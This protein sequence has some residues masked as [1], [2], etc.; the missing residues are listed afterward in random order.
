MDSQK[1]QDLGCCLYRPKS[2]SIRPDGYICEPTQ[3]HRFCLLILCY[4]VVYPS[5]SHKA[6]YLINYIIFARKLRD[7]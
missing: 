4:N 1:I 2:I 5:S 3:T 6:I 7:M